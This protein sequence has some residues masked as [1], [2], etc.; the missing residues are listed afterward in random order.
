MPAG[1]L[2]SHARWRP[3]AVVSAAIGL[4]AVATYWLAAARAGDPAG[5]A[6]W[7]A[8]VH[9]LIVAGVFLLLLVPRLPGWVN[10]HVMTS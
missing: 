10:R 8:F 6:T 4:L 5:A 2:Q 9:V 3:V 1:L 7:N